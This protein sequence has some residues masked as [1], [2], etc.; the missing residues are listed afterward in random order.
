MSTRLYDG[1]L[2]MY[3]KYFLLYW[4]WYLIFPYIPTTRRCHHSRQ[5]HVGYILIFVSKYQVYT[6]TLFCLFSDLLIGLYLWPVFEKSII[7]VI[8]NELVPDSVPRLMQ[9]DH[10]LGSVHAKVRE[11]SGRTIR[12]SGFT[13]WVEQMFPVSAPIWWTCKL[14]F[15]PYR[16]YCLFS[17][18]SL[19]FVVVSQNSMLKSLEF[20]ILTESWKKIFEATTKL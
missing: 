3:Y 4:S 12:T 1:W 13:E 14:V 11:S 6:F 16:H 9:L 8:K 10:R 5:W 15:V 18:H 2:L 17:L 19:S 7:N 20:K